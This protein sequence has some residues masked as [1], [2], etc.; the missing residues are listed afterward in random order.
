MSPKDTLQN[1][2]NFDEATIE[3]LRMIKDSAP[4]FIVGCPRSGTTL[5]LRLIRD[6]LD[7]GFGRDDGRFVR[8]KNLIDHYGDL[9]H[10]ANLASLLHD[11]F[12]EDDF[13]ERFRGL[14]LDPEE[15]MAAMEKRTYSEVVR[16][17]YA[18]FALIQGKA[19]WGDK[20]PRYVF[21]MGELLDM[22]PD[23][24]FV[25]VIRDGRDV[26]LSL[27]RMPWG[28][29]RNCYV[30][31]KYWKERTSAAQACGDVIGEE[32]YLEVKYEHLLTDPISV[33]QEILDFGCFD[34]DRDQVVGRFRKE[35]HTTL[36]RDNF[37]KWKTN[38]SASEVRVFEQMA[39][40]KLRELGYEI[41]NQ[42]L[43]GKPVRG[44]KIVYYHLH[45]LFSRAM[46]EGTSGISARLRHKVKKVRLQLRSF[47][48]AVLLS[49]SNPE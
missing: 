25:H 30:A 32:K 47:L 15:M 38:L 36:N 13:R 7:V 11:I 41:Q 40:D 20:T 27:F 19:R 33:F 17:I 18:A 49:Q 28:A 12:A 29:P 26:A 23:A 24:K 35:M 34:I 4:L 48:G 5:V 1:A 6:Y 46:R 3:K 31:A 43:I 42:S 45:N 44:D 14:T 8:F 2:M 9:N 21:H 39:G 37:D 22:F 16:H 10:T